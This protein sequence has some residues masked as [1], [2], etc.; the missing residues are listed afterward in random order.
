M[1]AYIESD[2]LSVS[3]GRLAIRDFERKFKGDAI[4]RDM[5]QDDSGG[6]NSAS[7]Q[8]HKTV[9]VNIVEGEYRDLALKLLLTLLPSLPGDNVLNVE[10]VLRRS[11]NS[12]PKTVTKTRRLHFYFRSP[13]V[14]GWRK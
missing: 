14:I 9:G 7:T 10:H 11:S 4:I 2:L 5:N 3:H 6:T 13:T 1:Q 8:Q 12:L